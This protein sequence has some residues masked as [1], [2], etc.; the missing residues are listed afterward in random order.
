[1]SGATTAGENAWRS[2]GFALGFAVAFVLV[3]VALGFLRP[4]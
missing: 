4:S 2:V 1:M 3:V